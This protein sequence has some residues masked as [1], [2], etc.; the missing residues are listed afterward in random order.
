MAKLLYQ[1]FFSYF[2]AALVSAADAYDPY[3]TL[4][5]AGSFIGT[6][7]SNQNSDTVIGGSTDNNIYVYSVGNSGVSLSQ[8]I[9]GFGNL[10]SISLSSDGETL[11]TTDRWGSPEIFKSNSSGQYA[12][13]QNI[14]ASNSSAGCISDDA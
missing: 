14:N 9:T 13:H 5:D 8:T 1:I 10:S 6:L 12:S 11:F 4:S 2:L 7:E 3:T